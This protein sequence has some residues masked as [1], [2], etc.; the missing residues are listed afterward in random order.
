MHRSKLL[1]TTA[2][3]LTVPAPAYAMSAGD[4]PQWLA[5][6]A[7]VAALI[8]AAVLL[9][10]ILAVAKIAEG[11]AIA[12]NIRYAVLAVI[13]MTASV[14]IGWVGRWLPA[15]SADH[16]RLGAD[17]LLVVAMALFSVYFVRVRLA[18]SRFL[19][20]LTGEEQLLAAVIDPDT[21]DG[22]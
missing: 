9:A 14:L 15:F 10:G 16:A 5:I 22:E 4:V 2:L 1:L 6:G 20:R 12:E 21:P 11:A 3:L 8:A 7:G 19:K 17:L 18:M 13:C